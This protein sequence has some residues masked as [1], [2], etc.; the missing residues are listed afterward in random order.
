MP[1]TLYWLALG[2]FCIGTESFMIA[3]LLPAMADDLGV[4]VA[5]AGQLVTVFSLSYAVGSPVLATVLGDWDR[6]VLLVAALAAFALANLVAA[7][8][9]GYAALMA[10][11]ILLALA[12]GLFMPTAN[13]VARTGEPTA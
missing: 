12:A 1:F 5:A 3:A 7:A 10:A 2:A 4:S 6:K 11:R 8:A 13:A 9:P